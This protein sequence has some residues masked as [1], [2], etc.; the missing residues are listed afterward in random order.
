MVSLCFII[1][2]FSPILI[3]LWLGSGLYW[4]C[5][6]CGHVFITTS[7]LPGYWGFDCYKY[8]FYDLQIVI[9][10]LGF[11]C[12][13]EYLLSQAPHR[14]DF[15]AK[16]VFSSKKCKLP[17]YSGKLVCLFYVFEY[18]LFVFFIADSS[19]G[20]I[21]VSIAQCKVFLFFSA[22][23]HSNIVSVVTFVMFTTYITVNC[24]STPSI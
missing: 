12:E 10:S 4:C 16:V 15:Y 20:D 22:L 9:P 14:D 2:L 7:C 8:I 6:E 17:C 23:V 24:A 13:F 19:T 5:M 11:I 3:Q 18:V 1:L 21:K